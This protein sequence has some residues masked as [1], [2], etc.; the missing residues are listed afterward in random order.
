MNDESAVPTFLETSQELS[1]V[2][3]TVSVLSAPYGEELQFSF[4]DAASAKSELDK[5]QAVRTLL[6]DLRKLDGRPAQAVREF[7][8]RHGA[9]FRNWGFL[10][11]TDPVAYNDGCTEDEWEIGPFEPHR[12]ENAFQEFA[13]RGILPGRVYWQPVARYQNAARVVNALLRV[14]ERSNLGL[15]MEKS[16]AQLLAAWTTWGNVVPGYAPSR[17]ANAAVGDPSALLSPLKFPS[18]RIAVAAV[19]NHWIFSSGATS[20]VTAPSPGRYEL[21]LQ[22]G[23]DALVAAQLV[24]AVFQLAP[25][26]KCKACCKDLPTKSRPH[27]R[28][29]AKYCDRPECVANRTRARVRTHRRRRRS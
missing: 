16:D 22:G 29:D 1:D 2:P 3:C 19:L 7:V 18:A 28:A 8:A 23:N 11:D 21:V 25:V 9:L 5:R 14:A 12:H 26:R 27:P 15:A 10:R 4:A 20:M 13:Y 24:H 6:R 17:A